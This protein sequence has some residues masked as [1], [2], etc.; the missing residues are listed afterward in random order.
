MLQNHRIAAVVGHKWSYVHVLAT[1]CFLCF[2]K[3]IYIYIY[4]LAVATSDDY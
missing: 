3:Y 4:A 2:L 1:P